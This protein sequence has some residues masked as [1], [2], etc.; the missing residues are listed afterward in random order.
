MTGDGL[1]IISYDETNGKPINVHFRDFQ[2]KSR[3]SQNRPPTSTAEVES[4]LVAEQARQAEWEGK[5]FLRDL[6]LG[7]F[8]FLA[9]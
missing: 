3:M 5:G 1:R 8:Q 9:N 2:E 4:R 7:K 6:F